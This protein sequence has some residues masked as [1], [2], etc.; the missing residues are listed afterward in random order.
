M[1]AGG[2]LVGRG[3]VSIRPEYEGDWSR[4]VNARASSAG[5]SGAGAFSKAFGAGLKTVG[6]LAA[7]AV[8]ANISGVA[9]SAAALAPALATAGT[10]AAALKIGLSGVGDAFKAAFADTSAQASSAA[11]AT[12]A[13]ESAQRGLAN[14]QR[15][16]AD[17]RVQAAERVREAQEQVVEAER[18][19]A[20]AQR[21]ARQVQGDLNDARREAARALQDMNQRLAESHLDEREAVLRLKQ[22]EEELKAAQ[23]K[24]G[25]T[26]EELERL[27]IAYERAKLNLTEQRTETKRLADDTKKANKAGI[28]GSEQVLSAKERIA[29]ADRNVADKQRAL[30]DAQAGVSKAHADGQRQ[31]EDA[32]RAVADAAAAVADAQAAAAAQTSQLDKA[33]AKLA[34]NARSFVDA[35]RGLAPAWTAMRMSVQNKLFEG[36]DTSVAQM[37]QTTIPILQRQLTATA[38]IWNAMAKSAMGAITEMGKSGMLEDIFEGANR[39]F[40]QFKDAPGQLITAFG[41]LSLAAQPAFERLMGQFAGAIAGFSDRI[42]AS[43]ASG[44][45]QQ[46]IETA[47]GILSQLGTLL[48]NVFGVVSQ[49]FK[50]ASDAGGE[51]L[52]VLSAVFEEI[53]RILA[54]PEVQAQM[55]ALFASVAQIVGAIVPVLGSLIQAVMPLLAAVAPVIASIAQALGP[56]L[57]QLATTLGTALMPIITALMPVVQQVGLALVQVVSAITPLLGPIAQL[58]TG[59][60]QALAPALDPIIRIITGLI[61]V[62]VGPLTTVITALMPALNLIGQ[63]IA[64]VFTALEPLLGPLVSLFAQV[65]SIVAGVFAMALEALMTALEPLMPVFM[66]L[67]ESVLQAMLPVLPIL[68][69][70]F[71]AIT[72]AMLA[73]FTPL[74]GVVAQ[75]AEQL[76][77]II[78]DLAPVISQL[79]GILAGALAAALPPL[80]DALLI[81]VNAFMPLFPL[82]GEILGM[83]VALGADLLA[84]LLPPL[85]QLVQAGVDLVVALLPILPPLAKIIGLVVELAVQVLSWLLPP[86]VSL[87][88]LLVGAFAG[89]LGTAIGWLADLVGILATVV[90]WVMDKVGPTLTWLWENVFRPVFTWIGDKAQWLW[91]EKIKPAWDLIKAGMKL[92]GDKIKE[93]WNE[94]AKPVLGWIGDKG[95]WLWNEAL[96]PAFDGI[97]KGIKAVGDSFEDAKNFIKKA[98]DKVQ[99]IAKKPVKFLINRVYNDGIVPTWNLVATAFGADPIKKMVLPKGF[100]SGGILPGYTPGKD[101]HRFFSPTGGGLELSG[102]EAIMRPEFT[103]AVGGGFVNYFNKVARTRGATGVKAALAPALGG[104][105]TTQRFAD[106]GIF[107]WIGNTAAGVGSAAW[108]GIK[109]GASWLTDGLESSARAGLKYVVDP[110]LKIFPGADT[111]F[112][113]MIRRIPHKILDAIFGYSKT[114]DKKGA[115]GIGGPRIQAALKWAK[116][117]HGLPYQWAGNGNPSWDCSGFMS[118]IESV[119]RGQ[120][121]HRR[122]ATGAFSGKTAPSGWV[123]N[124]K[125]PFR[126]GITNA[127]VGHTAGT[128]GGVNVESRGGDGVIV[129]KRARG[130]QSMLFRDVYGFQPGKFDSGGYLQPGMNLAYN[131]TGRPE[132]VFTTR[133][134]NALASMATD[135]G[136]KDLAVQVFVGDREITDIARAEVR[137]AQGELLSTLR[138][139]RK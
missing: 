22:A 103:R 49:I 45:L 20:D 41:H 38:G 61:S 100:A 7:V 12:R 135:G 35:V 52:G 11:S 98:W 10:A 55:R 56:V 64:R 59:V 104:N 112:G 99:D 114:A 40:S 91:R 85:L 90:S 130:A 19:L 132:P 111:N 24:K 88:S 117:Q 115:G 23:L 69:D 43:F 58:I 76:A 34:P 2:V 94:Y 48:G 95:K 14:A 4:S 139:G 78:A 126:I 108:N 33:M 44:G 131:G 107:D 5:R 136:L 97:K 77:P 66:Q 32:Q 137:T 68:A 26:P 30:A 1:A 134:A 6:G 89:A 67:I 120:R 123:L 83:V 74:A 25:V 110:L 15:S 128:L 21:D 124:G 105:E 125:S 121:P 79:A 116:T 87:V 50:A 13:V 31:V 65:A 96:K 70:A 138:A 122:W 27:N 47:F 29:D 37:G 54:L 3:Y 8:S 93:L 51:I 63:V 109:K 39:S 80:T 57:S 71:G 36:L 72:E 92:L 119:I 86:L 17:A 60:I 102:G 73:L 28:D 129:G 53:G 133:Q 62:L 16:L 9:A 18:D 101:V 113:K 82:L 75:L 106:G 118:A 81:L 127:G 46:G 42:A 84:Q